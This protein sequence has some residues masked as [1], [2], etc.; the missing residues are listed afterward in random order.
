MWIYPR[1]F[2][3]A[4]KM[5]FLSQLEEIAGRGSWSLFEIFCLRNLLEIQYRGI[6]D[7]KCFLEERE[8]VG[9]E[10]AC[11]SIT[12]FTNR[13]LT[14]S[15]SQTDFSKNRIWRVQGIFF[16]WNYKNVVNLTRET[17]I[18]KFAHVS[19]FQIVLRFPI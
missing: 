19:S 6:W 17:I 12:S 3:A 10:M 13:P 5:N 16:S 18:L 15:K 11:M 9:R 1:V 4:I 7:L 8:K 14:K 2:S